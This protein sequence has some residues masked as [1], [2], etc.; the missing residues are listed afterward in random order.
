MLNTNALNME[1]ETTNK[2]ETGQLAQGKSTE[3]F[4]TEHLKSDL[5]GRSVRGGAVTMAGQGRIF[6]WDGING[7]VDAFMGL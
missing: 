2:T 3:F 5:K 7:R 6:P 1:V 4:A